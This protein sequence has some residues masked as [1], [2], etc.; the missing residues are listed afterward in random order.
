MEGCG[1]VRKETKLC[2]EV[3]HPVTKMGGARGGK[4]YGPFTVSCTIS[5]TGDTETVRSRNSTQRNAVEGLKW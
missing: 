2:I 1:F 5:R 4:L 3:I